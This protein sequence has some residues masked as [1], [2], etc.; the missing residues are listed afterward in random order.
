MK[1]LDIAVL[2]A[3]LVE[4]MGW[5]FWALVA[6]AAFGVLA[7][8]FVLIRDRG[9]RSGRLLAAEAIGLI[10]AVAALAL[11]FWVTVSSPRDA[12]GAIDWLVIA[13]VALGGFVGV[14]ILSY[15]II[16]LAR[17]SGNKAAA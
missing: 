17:P 15:S 10:G 13:G 14:T 9:L 4:M 8:L 3:V 2:Y 11:M 16:G 12:G 1:E 6:L 7:F 5:L